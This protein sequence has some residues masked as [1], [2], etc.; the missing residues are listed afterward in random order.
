MIF[1]QCK[2]LKFVNTIIESYTSLILNKLFLNDKK[3][4]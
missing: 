2:K 4:T 1:L 3:V